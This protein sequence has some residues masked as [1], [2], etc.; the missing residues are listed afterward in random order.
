[1]Q[2][3]AVAT[4]EHGVSSKVLQLTVELEL[5]SLCWLIF[6]CLM[7][8]TDEKGQ[9]W[10]LHLARCINLLGW[11][12]RLCLTGSRCRRL[13]FPCRPV[14]YGGSRQ[15]VAASYQLRAAPS[16][17]EASVLGL[18][19]VCQEHGNTLRRNVEALTP[20]AIELLSCT[21]KGF[22]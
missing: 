6:H 15:S 2:T 14:S 7:I 20:A 5:N 11:D 10:P 18:K 1:M 21:T 4:P 16:R 17:S 9:R 22:L 12:L 13:Y 19:W 8:N 3:V